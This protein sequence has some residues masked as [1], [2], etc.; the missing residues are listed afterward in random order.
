MAERAVVSAI[1]RY[2]KTLPGCWSYKA[3]DRFT[4]GIPDIV[5]CLRGRFFGL[6]VKQ[7][8]GAVRPLQRAI[9][10]RIRSCGGIAAVVRSVADVK[11]LFE[12]ETVHDREKG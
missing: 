11:Q 12:E 2:L 9:V 10:E 7:P 1:R 3:S 8:G 6:E 4:A 5:G